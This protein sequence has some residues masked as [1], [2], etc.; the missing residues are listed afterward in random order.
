MITR[1]IVC[2]CLCL[3]IFYILF[4]EKI[5][6]YLEKMTSVTGYNDDFPFIAKKQDISD[7]SIIMSDFDD[8]ILYNKNE[9][10]LL[11]KSDN[12]KFTKYPYYEK[13]Q[14]DISDILLQYIKSKLVGRFK[15]DK[16][17]IVKAPYDVYYEGI[18]L[19]TNDF[20]YFRKYILSVDVANNTHFFVRTYTFYVNIETSQINNITILSI[21]HDSDAENLFYKYDT[22][23]NIPK[24]N[25]YS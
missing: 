18:E 2:I 5:L 8:L 10:P 12:T 13:F 3:L 11:Y 15:S 19:I 14:F 24:Y 4:S 20:N 23:N 6:F 21:I 16:I 7:I 22:A 25:V 9:F 1:N 17:S